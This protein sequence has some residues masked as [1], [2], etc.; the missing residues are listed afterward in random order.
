MRVQSKSILA[1]VV[2]CA[3][4]VSVFSSSVN[5]LRM[6]STLDTESNHDPDAAKLVT[7]DIQNFWRAYDQMNPDNDLMVFKR[8]YLNKGSAGLKDFSR[9]RFTV[10]DLVNAVES[11]QATYSSVRADSLKLDLATQPTRAS[12]RKL[13]DLYPDAVFPDVYFLIGANN[14]GGTVADSGLL[15]GV[16]RYAN[17]IEN[18]VYTVAHELI[19]YQQKY[20]QKLDLIGLS[21]KEGSADFIGEL[22]SGKSSNPQLLAFGDAHAHELWP[23]F[24]KDNTQGDWGVWLYDPNKAKARGMPKDMGY[25]FGY[26][27][28][29]ANYKK[30]SD[31]R[32]AVKDILEI[33]DLNQ[34]LHDSGYVP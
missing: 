16:G 25:Y 7:S 19:H 18:I 10:C 2:L 29:E 21:I 30:T 28:A 32:R 6:K 9:L 3:G 15:I 20:P 1:V 22:I 17:E 34:F 33:H 13:K 11:N 23:T 8:E 5:P 12:F 4:F 24:M 14:S 27:I 31:K 26:K